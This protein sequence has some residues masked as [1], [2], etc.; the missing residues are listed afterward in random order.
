MKR[1]FVMA[2]L[3]ASQAVAQVEPEI[4]RAEPVTP[5]LPAESAA[6]PVAPAASEAPVVATPEVVSEGEIR[7]LPAGVI[8]DPVMTLFDE[9]NAFYSRK[10]YDLAA[11]KYGEFLQQRAA[12]AERQAALFR[13]GESLRTLKR[14]AEALA[15]L[16]TLVRE[17]TSGEF[18]GPAA[19]R[20][21]EMQYAAQDYDA[22]AEAFRIASEQV[23]DPKLRLVAKFY[24]GRSLDGAGRTLEALSAY[25]AVAAQEGDNPYRE[26]A[27]FDLAEA[28]ARA[29]LTDGAFRQF[30]KLFETAKNPAIRAGSAVKAGLLAID[31]KDYQ[32]ARPLLEAAAEGTDAPAW[33][34]AANVGL[35]RLDYEEEKY[36]AVAARA[37]KLLNEATGSSRSDVLLMAANA[38]R[39]LGKHAQALAL[40]DRL[41]ASYPDS[42]AAREAGFHR[43][44]SLV[45][46]GDP[47]A[48]AQI[49]KFLATTDDSGDKARASLLKAEVLFA[50]KDY[51]GAEKLYAAASRG[52]DAGPYRSDALYKLAW[53]RLQQKKYDAAISTLTEFIGQYPRAPQISSAFLQRALAQLQSGQQEEALADFAAIIDKQKGAPERESAMLQRALLLGKMERSGEMTE[54]FRRLLDEFPKTTAAAQANFWIG[55]V[56]FDAK[57]YKDAIPALEEARRLDAKKYGERASVRL[58]L[59]HYYLE[60]RAAAAAE[61]RILGP[62]KTPAEVRRWLGTSALEAGDFAGARE[63]LEQ[64]GSANDADDETR[65][66]LARAQAGAKDVAG[67]RA[68]LEKLIPRLQQPKEKARACLM[69][70]DVL[71][72]SG[73]G[74]AAKSQAEE[75]LRLQPEGRMN[76]EAR[77]TNARALLAQGRHDD[78][79]RAFMAIALLY[80]EKDIT[81]QALALAEDA[82]RRAQNSADADRAREELQRR[83]PD[84]KPST[85]P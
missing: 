13:L 26:R 44:V 46:E 82:Y 24:E 61:A 31:A 52:P 16:Q 19:Y 76:A 63:F 40:Y 2:V 83:Y 81:P 29:G 73:D 69:L 75:A 32:A 17:Y 18:L 22:A 28:D 65:F 48:E 58:L 25:R 3:A 84:Y 50:R 10:M 38:Q 80:D 12:G 14:T 66:A 39:Q 51:E 60:D 79:A 27:I 41:V 72:E 4:R 45:A 74:A 1:I 35:L 67:A 68:T 47:G 30:R 33:K 49:D 85:L 71:I 57:Q 8:V 11:S 37:E 55:Y 42:A 56:A 36:S 6:P 34:T 21:G 64:L 15:A 43:L 20:L 59:S 9:G 78:A 70:A 5:I 53:C 23:G 62:Q 7:V 77:M 54:T